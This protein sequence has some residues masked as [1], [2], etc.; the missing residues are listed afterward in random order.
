VSYAFSFYHL[1]LTYTLSGF[2][3]DLDQSN[4]CKDI[5]KIKLI[6]K[7]IAIPQK[8]YNTTKSLKTPEE[9]VEYYFPDFIAFTDYTQQQQQQIPKPEDKIRCKACILFKQ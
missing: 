8:T 2:L 4:V 1:Y 7:C 6:R 3:F 9:E 5:Q